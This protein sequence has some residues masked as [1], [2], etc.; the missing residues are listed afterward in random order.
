MYLKVEFSAE[1]L[2]GMGLGFDASR[3]MALEAN[4]AHRRRIVDRMH[5]KV[6]HSAQ[7]KH[8]SK[9]HQQK[10]WEER[11]QQ[12]QQQSSRWRRL[13]ASAPA[14]AP[15]LGDGASVLAA[16][17]L[18]RDMRHWSMPAAQI[19]DAGAVACVIFQL[20]AEQQQQQ[21]QGG[22]G[23]HEVKKEQEETTTTKSSAV[24][25]AAAAAK[26]A[27]TLQAMH[28]AV[29]VVGTH[30]RGMT[31]CDQRPVVFEPDVPK[32]ASNVDVCVDLDADAFK[33]LYAERVLCPPSLPEK[34]AKGGADGEEEENEDWDGQ[35]CRSAD[36]IWS[37]LSSSRS[38]NSSSSYRP[39]R[40]S[41]LRGVVL[42]VSA[43]TSLLVAQRAAGPSLGPLLSGAYERGLGLVPLLGSPLVAGLRAGLL[44]GLGQCRELGGRLSG[45]VV[46]PL[47]GSLRD[48]GA[49]VGAWASASAAALRSSSRLFLLQPLV[50]LL[51]ALREY[52]AKALAPALRS[53]AL[54]LRGA[55]SKT[56]Q[57]ATAAAA[58]NRALI[59]K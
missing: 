26:Q 46:A 38:S 41:F 51:R 48:G 39:L 43:A 15:R 6:A 12:Q 30:T 13:C 36:S 49:F 10:E 55:V 8:N 50:E 57:A 1:E 22:G 29:E 28:V 47:L 40:T 16:R 7:R 35:S 21:Q 25:S 24:S 23:A 20:L 31:V 56:A 45:S 9:K 34:E 27:V 59:T 58:N 52:A 54:L 42:S 32:Q 53:S 5:A 2:E 37:Q 19:G 11:K 44:Q 17:L 4:E 14:A 18:H 33:K 3:R